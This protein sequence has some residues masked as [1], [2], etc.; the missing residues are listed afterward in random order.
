MRTIILVLILFAWNSAFSTPE[1]FTEFHGHIIDA[2]DNSALS[3][4]RVELPDKHI[5]TLTD[6]NGHFHFINLP[7]IT[8]KVI[9][10][11]DGYISQKRLVD[12]SKKDMR[13]IR[14]KLFPKSYNTPTVYVT[15]KI[16]ANKFDEIHE[17]TG[18]V[19]D[20]D[21]VKELGA[22]IAATLSNEVGVSMRSMGPAP[23]R[24]VIRGL[25]GNRIA[26]AE[27]GLNIVDLSASSSDHAVTVEPSTVDRIEILRGPKTLLNT[28]TTIGGVVNIIRDDVPLTLPD[29]FSGS[30]LL[31]AE[32]VNSGYNTALQFKMPLAKFGI[33]AGGSLRKAG[34]L[35]TPEGLIGNT[36]ISNFNY[37]LGAGLIEDDYSIG[38]GINEFHSD[39][40]IPGGFVGAHPKGVNISMTKRLIQAKS[41]FHFKRNI[42]DIVELDFGRTYYSHKEFESNG[43]LGAEYIFKNYAA[44]INV[45]H[46][47]DKWFQDGSFGVSLFERDLALG[48][49][50]FTPPTNSFNISPYFYESIKLGKHYLELG[51]RYSHTRI[52]PDKEAS[53]KIG[54]LRR[55]VFNT[56]SASISLMHEINDYFY[57]GINL[58]RSTRAPSAEELF[59]LGPH[60]AA[61][62]YEVGNPDLKQETGYGSEIFT[63]LRFDGLLVSLTGFYNYMDYYII[64]ENTGKQ[65]VQQLLPIYAFRGVPASLYGFEFSGQSNLSRKMKIKMNLSY[66]L[67]ENRRTGTALP[68]IPPLKGNM[69]LEYKPI[70]TIS[71]SLGSDFAAAQNRVGD[72]EETTAGYM[73]FNLSAFYSFTFGEYLSSISLS[74]E[75][76]FNKIYRNHLSRIKTVF[77]EPGRNFRFTY[78]L[79]I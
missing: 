47:K 68:F 53:T 56:I 42:F 28:T 3:G 16:Y 4:V 71:L 17:F 1:G 43:S 57:A 54:R 75:N 7:R 62:S 13:K 11:K 33:K 24:P 64:S 34:N 45:E 35:N 36:E 15:D 9:F 20:D 10:S 2:A 8:F 6:A 37:S 31:Y 67:A 41:L 50:V 65:N 44:R 79:N 30:A 29:K 40:G 51:L 39:Y 78:K 38:C 12:L 63:F 26:M 77:P 72:F 58:S 21:M 14:L 52:T 61:Y 66:T 70:Q 32:S 69:S 5:S 46:K 60:L 22:T 48:G 23:A 18:A 19:D 49:Y 59:S 55:R 74:F 27:D 76:I 73:V 25:G